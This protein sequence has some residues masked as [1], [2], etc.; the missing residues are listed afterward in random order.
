[1]AT[2]ILAALG[3]S[4]LVVTAHQWLLREIFKDL[5]QTTHHSDTSDSSSG[6][7]HEQSPPTQSGSY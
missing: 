1:M 5:P 3:L 7:N 2:S 6:L 4:V